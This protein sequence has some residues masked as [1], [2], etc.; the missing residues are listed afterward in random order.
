MDTSKQI[1]ELMQRVAQLESKLSSHL[2]D[3]VGGTKTLRKNIRLDRD[4]SISIGQAQ[5]LTTE[6]VGGTSSDF[7]VH[8]V[9]LGSDNL[10]TGF[11]NKSSNMQMDFVHFPNGT[12]SYVR[13]F[14]KPLVISNEN[15]SVSTTF[16]GNTVTIA[17]YD[18]ATDELAGALINIYNSSGTHIESQTIASNTATVITISDT[19]RASTSGGKFMIYNPILMGFSDVILNRVYVQEGTTIGGIRFGVG[20]TAGGQNGLLYMNAAGNLFW[21]NKLGSSVQ[22]N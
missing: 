17:G 16:G 13:F 9:S 15:S 10:D 7:Y 12:N 4:Q 11:T 3:D 20:P 14:R 19:W 18:F 21:R 22:L 2:H 8:S 6:L 1:N 5:H